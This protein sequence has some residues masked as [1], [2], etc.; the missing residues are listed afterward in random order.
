MIVLVFFFRYKGYYLLHN[1]SYMYSLC[2]LTGQV[3]Q[4][5]MA[6]DVHNITYEEV[7]T[8]CLFIKVANELSI[9]INVKSMVIK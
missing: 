3:Y 9:L 5:I 1:W 8:D 4:I 6:I 7:E 2:I